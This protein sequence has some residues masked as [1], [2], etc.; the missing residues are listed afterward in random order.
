VADK[1][2]DWD[3]EDKEGNAELYLKIYPF[4]LRDFM[5]RDDIRNLLLANFTL[6]GNPF[7][8]FGSNT[9]GLRQAI[10]YKSILDSGDN[11]GEKIKPVIEL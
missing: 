1:D 9:E 4:L 11:L 6:N 7:I 5:H 2:V 8:D 10:E 3:A